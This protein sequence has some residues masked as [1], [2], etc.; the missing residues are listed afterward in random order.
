MQSRLAYKTRGR[1]EI[2][3]KQPSC[4]NAAAKH[5]RPTANLKECNYDLQ[6]GDAKRRQA[7]V[8]SRNDT[9]QCHAKPRL[10]LSSHRESSRVWGAWK[11]CRSTT[12]ESGSAYDRQ[13][14]GGS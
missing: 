9:V 14:G 4:I 12:C 2:T 3:H 11:G 7:G 13:V 6:L 5:A 8:D 10:W 1:Q